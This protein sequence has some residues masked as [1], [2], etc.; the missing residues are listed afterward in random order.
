MPIRPG[1]GWPLQLRMWTSAPEVVTA[2][3]IVFLSTPPFH[4]GNKFQMWLRMSGIWL[5]MPIELLFRNS[6]FPSF[7]LLWPRYLDIRILNCHECCLIDMYSCIF[8]FWHR[9]LRK[10]V[11][12]IWGK[13]RVIF[14]LLLCEKRKI[15]IA[16]I[17]IQTTWYNPIS[18]LFILFARILNTF[19]Y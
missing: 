16:W 9:Y 19:V 12:R 3:R 5:I 1:G 13:R 11:E 14:L 7:V 15:L 8:F 4:Y 10:L 2:I 6:L 17:T 18:A